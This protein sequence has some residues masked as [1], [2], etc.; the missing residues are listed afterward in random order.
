M[1]LTKASAPVTFPTRLLISSAQLVVPSQKTAQVFEF[2]QVLYDLSC[3]LDS[4]IN[5]SVSEH[6][7]FGF[8]RV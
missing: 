7:D 1:C 6:H 8:V 4:I 5:A 3:D 2:F